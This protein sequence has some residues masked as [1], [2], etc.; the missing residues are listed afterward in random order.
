MAQ[1][2]QEKKEKMQTELEKD[3]LIE[4]MKLLE[5]KLETLEKAAE[6]A[7]AQSSPLTTTNPK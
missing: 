4:R 1:R 5:S 2:R 3:A 6:A 7:A